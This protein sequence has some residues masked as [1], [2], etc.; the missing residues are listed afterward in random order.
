MIGRDESLGASPMEVASFR[1]CKSVAT[2][3][4]QGPGCGSFCQES[5]NFSAET[6]RYQTLSPLIIASK[7]TYPPFPDFALP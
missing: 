4:L 5:A 1:I 6:R 7:Q 2:H 3:P